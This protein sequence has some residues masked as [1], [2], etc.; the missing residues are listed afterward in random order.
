MK[1]KVEEED[2][3]KKWVLKIMGRDNYNE[4]TNEDEDEENNNKDQAEEK[5]GEEKKEIKNMSSIGARTI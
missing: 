2:G 5:G 1:E 4:E 3:L